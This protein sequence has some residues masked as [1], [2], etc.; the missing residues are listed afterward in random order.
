MYMQWAFERRRAR[1]LP[2]YL[3]GTLRA[4]IQPP[5]VGLTGK[6]TQLDGEE[7]EQK[8]LQKTTGV[9]ESYK[10]IEPPLRQKVFRPPERFWYSCVVPSVLLFVLGCLEFETKES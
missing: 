10:L 7:H 4:T 6:E 9:T 5:N 8:S 2:G 1:Q 3:F